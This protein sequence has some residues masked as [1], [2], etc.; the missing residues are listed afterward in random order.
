MKLLLATLVWSAAAFGQTDSLV[1]HIDVTA[2][3]P[4]SVV[5]LD[6]ENIGT[7]PV[8]GVDVAAGRH[9]LRCASGDNLVWPAAVSAETLIVRP[10][11]TVHCHC[12]VPRIYHLVTDPGSA[13]IMFGDSVIAVTPCF[14]TDRYRGKALT[15][16]APGYQD[17]LIV[18]PESGGVVTLRLQPSGSQ[19][20]PGPL[21]SESQQQDMLPVYVSSGSAILSGV[22]AAYFKIKADNYYSDYLATGDPALLDKIHR[23][24]TI[25]G[26]AL[27]VS[28][29]RIGALTYYLFSR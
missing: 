7:A 15:A 25:S 18:L 19:P 28:Q 3:P 8:P 22:A 29:V 11:D 4:G 16:R 5:F 17:G 27:V 26:I 1:A 14:L 20:P 10:G 21:I 13:D 12:V 23:F 6:S 24:D 9:L 2:D